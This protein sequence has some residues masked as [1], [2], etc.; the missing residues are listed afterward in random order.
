MQGKGILYYKDGTIKYEGDFI[1]GKFE[2][3]GKYTF[4]SG[5]Y[6][7]GEWSDNKMNGIGK[8]YNKDGTVKH[9]GHFR[10]D[11]YIKNWFIYKN[12]V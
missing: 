4:E 10:N 9:D 11:K 3:T 5:N 7:I 12:F 2:G 8:Y 1:E 6:Y